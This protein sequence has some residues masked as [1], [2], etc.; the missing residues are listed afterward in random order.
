MA[1]KYMWMTPRMLQ[2]ADGIQRSGEIDA[3]DGMPLQQA[4]AVRAAS[5][6]IT[7]RLGLDALSNA[8]RIAALLQN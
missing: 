5:A 7:A 8:D 2:L 3:V 4:F 1:V 6:S